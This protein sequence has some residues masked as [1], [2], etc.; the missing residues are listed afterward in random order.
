MC[1][2]THQVH[3]PWLKSTCVVPADLLP[4][5]ACTPLI[6][7][8][9]AL[10]VPLAHLRYL[11]TIAIIAGNDQSW[12]KC[13]SCSQKFGGELA[14]RLAEGAVD[15]QKGKELGDLDK[16]L[17]LANLANQLDGIGEHEKAVKLHR[18][19]LKGLQQSKNLGCEHRHTLACQG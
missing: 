7:R 17:A 12:W 1:M 19:V 2:S 13:S 11:C 15:A 10:S 8:L 3:A 9:P 4:V 5:H 18:T 6:I 14:L 16:L